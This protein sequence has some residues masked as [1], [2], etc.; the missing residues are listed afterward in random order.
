M[1]RGGD[2]LHREEGICL[3]VARLTARPAGFVA[4]SELTASLSGKSR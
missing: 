2:H 3:E 4:G 1:C